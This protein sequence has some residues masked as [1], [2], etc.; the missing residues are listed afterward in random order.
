MCVSIG[1]GASAAPTH[2]SVTQRRSRGVST[3]RRHISPNTKPITP[4]SM[5]APIAGG[6]GVVM[7]CSYCACGVG[8]A[9][10]AVGPLAHGCSSM[11]SVSRRS[12][13]P[14]MP[15]AGSH[16]AG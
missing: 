4:A 1:I 7:M 15:M 9:V 2:A 3:P 5:Y 14:G 12:V 8:L 13:G 10:V 11:G 6:A 16:H